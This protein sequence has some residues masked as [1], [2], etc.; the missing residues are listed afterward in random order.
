MEVVEVF[1]SSYGVHISVK[2]IT[3]CDVV[4]TKFHAFPLSEGMDHFCLSATNSI[5][6][7]ADRM[8]NAVEVVVD[9]GAG[10]DEERSRHTAEVE[11]FRELLLERV[12]D[13]L[14]GDFGGLR[15]EF[16]VV[17]G[18]NDKHLNND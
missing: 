17:F 3:G 4:S 15:E 16:E 12:L 5:D 18:G 14:D 9:T 10:E 6:G 11:S 2:A 7:E 8:L 13:V 1:K